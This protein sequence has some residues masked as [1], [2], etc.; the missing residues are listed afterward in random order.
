MANAIETIMRDE[1][2]GLAGLQF[3]RHGGVKLNFLA[4]LQDNTT[5]GLHHNWVYDWNLGPGGMSSTAIMHQSAMDAMVT[6]WNAVARESAKLGYGQSPG[7]IERMEAVLQNRGRMAAGARRMREWAVA[8]VR[9]LAAAAWRKVRW[10]LFM[11]AVLAAALAVGWACWWWWGTSAPPPQVP[12]PQVPPQPTPPPQAGPPP[13]A[14]A[15]VETPAAFVQG[16]AA[17]APW[18][19]HGWRWVVAT[20]I[21]VV[22][23]AIAVVHHP[24]RDV[25]LWVIDAVLT[26][27]AVDVMSIL[28]LPAVM[29][30]MAVFAE[31]CGT[32]MA[33]LVMRLGN[34]LRPG[35][36]C[37]PLVVSTKATVDKLLDELAKMGGP[38]SVDKMY[39]VLLQESVT[40]A[41]WFLA[42]YLLAE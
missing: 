20:F 13:N 23:G 10:P 9:A 29:G 26:R 14:T 28:Q 40:W 19:V 42:V 7:T 39:D 27:L 16:G 33:W 36:Y 32:Y 2:K 15:H 21:C 8:Q 37:E 31:M 3:T 25:V 22:L 30:T 35:S 11:M 1:C 12:P 5:A 6:L 38:P 24:V 18:T 4:M 34:H 17:S 41:L